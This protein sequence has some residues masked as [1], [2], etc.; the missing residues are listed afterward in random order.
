MNKTMYYEKNGQKHFFTAPVSMKFAAKKSE[1]HWFSWKNVGIFL[2]LVL[3]GVG[4]AM[5]F[6]KQ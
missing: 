4:V 1:N 6:K 3:L 5:Y 2:L